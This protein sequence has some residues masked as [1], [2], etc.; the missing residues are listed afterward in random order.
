[1]EIENC[2]VEDGDVIVEVSR[3]EYPLRFNIRNDD[4]W[5]VPNSKLI[6]EDLETGDQFE[7]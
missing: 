2:Y 1:M 3:D 7:K 6:V 4:A 5:P